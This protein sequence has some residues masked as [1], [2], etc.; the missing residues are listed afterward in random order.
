V[1]K[2]ALM[3]ML[4]TVMVAPFAMSSA[5]GT[6]ASDTPECCVKKQGCCPSASCCAGG[7]HGME[8]HC[9]LHADAH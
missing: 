9:M 8:S 1:K 5:G 7:N 2:F 6:R 3:A 4:A